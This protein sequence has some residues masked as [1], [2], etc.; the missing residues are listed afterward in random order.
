[1]SFEGNDAVQINV[2]R[3]GSQ[4]RF[5]KPGY[6]IA[7][8]EGRTMYLRDVAEVMNA[9]REQRSLYRLNGKEAVEV[10]VIQ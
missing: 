10:S 7:S 6:P 3:G 5:E 1:M 2:G 8:M 4:V 9:P